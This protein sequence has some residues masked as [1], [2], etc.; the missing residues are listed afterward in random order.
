MPQRATKSNLFVTKVKSTDGSVGL[1]PS[2]G[3]GIMDMAVTQFRA[4]GAPSTATDTATLTAAQLLA[5]ILI[6]TP[7]AAAAYTL[8]LATDLDAA[9]PN[10]VVNTSFDFS[11]INK[12]GGANT[13]TMT[14]N[15]GWTITNQG[16]MT[17]AQ[18]VS[19]RFRAR[20]TA[21]G[22]WSLY[23]LS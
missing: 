8:P 21:A 12:S 22:A 14:T 1:T 13:I 15:T 2:G 16:V 4:Q 3:S 7:T 20:K 9:L 17:V 10:A 18:N 23:R 6:A 5:G 19:G 11:V